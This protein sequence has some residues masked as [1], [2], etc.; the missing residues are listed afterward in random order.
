MTT[1]KELRE[2]IKNLPDDM[3]VIAVGYNGYGQDL[4]SPTIESMVY[5]NTDYS[6]KAQPKEVLVFQ[7]DSYLFESEDIGNSEMWMNKEDYNEAYEFHDENLE[8]DEDDKE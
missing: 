8:D 4:V 7:I 1:I 5:D 2:I 6:K 3:E